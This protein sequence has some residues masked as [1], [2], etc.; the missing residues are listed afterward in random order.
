MRWLLEKIRWFD[1]LAISQAYK[2]QVGGKGVDGNIPFGTWVPKNFY[3][4]TESLAGL[5]T[6]TPEQKG[7]ESNANQKK[8][9]GFRHGL[10]CRAGVRIG[11]PCD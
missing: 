3:L 10:A 2:Q 5:M 7:A 8:G 4:L 11:G 1:V 6:A 9:S